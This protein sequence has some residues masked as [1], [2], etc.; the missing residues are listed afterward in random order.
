MADNMRSDGTAHDVQT[1]RACLTH[2]DKKIPLLWCS[3]K[4][5]RRE[6]PNEGR[7]WACGEYPPFTWRA[8]MDNLLKCFSNQPTSPGNENYHFCA[9]N[10]CN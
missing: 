4:G 2:S 1:R 10:Y 5:R 9:M 8:L 3:H 6:Q 7:E